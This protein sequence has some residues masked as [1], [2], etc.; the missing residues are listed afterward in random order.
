M[1]RMEI[2][3]RDLLRGSAAR[4][5]GGVS[6]AA[7]L[8]LSAQGAERAATQAARHRGGFGGLASEYDLAE[9]LVFL[10][11]A[12]IGTLPRAV[13][14]TL[15]GLQRV[16]EENPWLYIWGGAWDAALARTRGKLAA[17]LGCRANELAVT[18][19]TTEGF[20]LL[21]QGLPLG[22]GDEVLFSSLN[23]VGA[24]RAWFHQA[25]VR[26]FRV[27]RFAFPVADAPGLSAADVAAIHARAIGPATRVLVVPHIDNRVGL[28]HPLKEIAAGA[29]AAGVDFVAVDGA[30]APGMIPVDL[31]AAGIDF[32][33]TSA[34]KWLQGPKGLGLFYLAG[35]LRETLRPMWVTWGQEEKDWKGT[36]R[37]FEDYGTRNL[38][39][40][41]ALEA[42]LAFQEGLGAGEQ[43]RH[44]ARLRAGAF[45][46]VQ[47]A[48]GLSWHSPREGSLATSI[49]S[50]GLGTRD[51]HAV[52]KTLF[53]KHRIVVRPFSTDGT[54]TLR[55]SPNTLNTP[56]EIDALFDRLE[57][58]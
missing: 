2:S 46:R 1:G 31:H 34:H 41:L 9:G 30:Q 51:S 54:Q 13:R 6:L 19:N 36:A 38:A 53:E 37:L 43:A 3:R 5:A 12:S 39:N 40:V 20:N 56:A 16:C 58:A 15:A 21:A 32:Y 23:H 25:E 57:S 35:R 44:R 22:P 55:I 33:A 45:E 52:A 47:A 48:T 8:R 50:V 28:R 49:V 24:S 27:R 14:A 4:A 7:L 42:A 29:H 26:G 10:N 11:H 17:W 18:H